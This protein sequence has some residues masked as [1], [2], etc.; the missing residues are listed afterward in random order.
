MYIP[1][2]EPVSPRYI[3]INPKSNKVH[4]LVPVVGGQEISTDNTCKATVALRDFFDGGALRELTAY[5]DA[6][7]FDIALVEE[8][9]P[10]RIAKEA[11]LAQIEGYIEAVQA[12]RQSY[13]DAVNAFMSKPSNLYSIQ[14]RPRNQDSQSRVVHPAFNVERKNDGQGNPLS[15]LYKAMYKAFPGIK[16]AE[17]DPRTKLTSTV[18]RVLPQSPSFE[19]IQ[20][21]LNAQCI[22]LFGTSVDFTMKAD[23]TPVTKIGID[24]S[25][26]FGTDAT[27]EDYIDALLGFCAPNLWAIIPTP[28]FYG[29][30]SDS[31]EERTERLSILTQFFLANL[32]VYCRA[33]GLTKENFG[34][35]FDNSEDL[36]DELA[37][38]VLTALSK[39]IDVEECICHFF[40][41]HTDAFKLVRPLSAEDLVAIKQKFERTYR[42]VTATKENPHM[43]DLMILDRDATGD[44]AKFITHQGSICVD[45]AE[46]VD[47]VAASANPDYF[48]QIRKD[49]AIHPA[50]ISNEN[51]WVAN[52]VEIEPETLLA[53]L[54][55]GQFERLPEAAKNA[56]RTHPSFQSRQFLH[57]VAKGKQDEA[58]ALLTATPTNTQT[59]LRTPGMFTDYSGRTFNCTA[60]EY[61]YWAKD[62][63]MR[64]MLERLMDS[65]T[66]A[67]MCERIEQIEHIDT[68]T[69]KPVGLVYQQHGSEHRSVHF[70]ITPLRTALQEY[71]NGFN[72]WETA[73]KWDAIIAAWMVVGKAQRNVP[74]HVAHEYCRKD[75][76]FDPTPPFN[77]ENLP[78]TLAFYNWNTNRDDSWYPLVASNSGLGFDFA[79]LRA[80]RGGWA[81]GL[82]GGGPGRG[83]GARVDLTA[84]TRLDEVRTAELKQSREYLNPPAVSHGMS[85]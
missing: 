23:S 59:L 46:I 44:C 82:G 20:R 76:S 29:I 22:S 4:L 28:P 21:V 7:A 60:Y 70:D 47:S 13:G 8:D 2:I 50:E 35:I 40:N 43:D 84:I 78:R 26:G 52:G 51:E 80:R 11:R 17:P 73:R 83:G 9:N 37:S 49:F 74:A 5:K 39:G 57:D 31:D 64:R 65:D 62:T 81:W 69:G 36:S 12:M 56:C 27:P 24:T 15:S 42:T 33:Q 75:R 1:F 77:E 71:V 67:L 16:I 19:E 45:F 30:P 14:L 3:H 66:K 18:L 6:L 72:A 38:I 61:A 79:L 63:H 34:S 53:R 85:M 41:T 54:T 55:D 68:A 48:D 58:K 25:M 10:Q 32:N